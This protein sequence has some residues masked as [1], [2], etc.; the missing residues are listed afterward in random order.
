MS[1]QPDPT[2]AADPLTVP[3]WRLWLGAGIVVALA[4][5]LLV[6]LDPSPGRTGDRPPPVA[7]TADDDDPIRAARDALRA[8][9]VFAGSGALDALLPH[10]A[11]AGPQ[12]RQLRAEAPSLAGQPS[13][14]PAYAFGLRDAE[15]VA[16]TQRSAVV[17]GMVVVSRPGEPTQRYRWDIV[18]RRD[19]PA[20]PWRV[21]T[22]KTV[23]VG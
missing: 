3:A 22:T 11:V 16:N 8:W 23:P 13:S 17:R 5:G 1:V 7:P 4:A 2:P 14:G 6:S 9:A 19:H 10:F 20:Q 15:L 12:F 21:W 18:L